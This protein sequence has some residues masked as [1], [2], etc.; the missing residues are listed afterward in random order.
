MTNAVLYWPSA[1]LSPLRNKLIKPGGHGLPLL[2]VQTSQVQ[3]QVI[4]VDKKVLGTQ[5]ITQYIP[6][7]ALYKIKLSFRYL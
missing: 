5:Y 3:Q 1:H 7:A 2:V 4:C 6:N